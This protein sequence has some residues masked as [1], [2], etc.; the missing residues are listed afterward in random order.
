MDD[1]PYKSPESDLSRASRFRIPEIL[2]Y[3]AAIILLTSAAIR[4]FSERD[5]QLHHYANL[6]HDLSGLCLVAA[7]G[8]L[9]WPKFMAYVRSRG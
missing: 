2:G 4:W 3:V 9:G 8:W 5:S 6:A 7:A 1:N